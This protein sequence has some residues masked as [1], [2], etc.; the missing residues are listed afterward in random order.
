MHEIR[1]TIYTL[2][3]LL[4]LSVSIQ[5]RSYVFESLTA[6]NGLSD[7]VVNAIYKDKAGYVWIGTGNS[8]AKYD[9]THLK[10]YL[11]P[12]SNEKLKRVNAITELPTGEIWI[13]NGLGLWRIPKGG[14]ELEKIIP[15]E[16][17]TAVYSLLTDSHGTL[18][19]GEES[20]LTIYKKGQFH[21]FSMETNQFSGWNTITDM[22]IQ[23][24]TTLWMS[25]LRG[26]VSFNLLTKEKLFYA[27][28][29]AKE[30]QIAF[31][32]IEQIGT[33][34]YLG[35]M[36]QGILSFNT[37]SKEFKSYVN[38]GCNVISDLSSDKKG[39]L[40]VATDGN[41]VHFIDTRTEEIT[42]SFRHEVGSIESIRSNSVYSLLVDREGEIWMGYYQMGLDYTLYQS[43]QFN[44][45]KYK[46]IFDSKDISIRTLTI[47]EEEKLIG[48]R[49]GLHF[50]DEKRERYI[51]YTSP[52]LRSSMIIC[53]YYYK[54]EYYIG[55]YGGGMYIFNPK[56]LTIRNFET[57]EED[58]FIKGQ[59]FS[60]T[61]DTL[62]Q[63]WIGT[64]A[65]LYCYKEGQRVHKFT[66]ANSK[67][68]EGN[69]YKI[70]FDSTSKGWICT[71]N[72][73]CI[74]EPSSSSLKTDI[75]PD[76]F[77]HKE[78]IRVIFED[79]NHD[80]YFMPDKGTMF[81]SNMAMSSFRRVQPETPL[82][83]KDGLFIIEDIK[84]WLWIGT[85][86]GIFKYDKKDT[87]IPYN[88]VDG[89]PNPTFTYCEP[90]IDKEGKIW[91]G[92]S[93]GLLYVDPEEEFNNRNPYPITFWSFHANGNQEVFPSPTENKGMELILNNNQQN[94]TIRF[95]DLTYTKAS[96]VNYEY[97]L[98]GEEN[99]WTTLRGKS[100]VT[101]YGLSQGSYRFCVRIAGNPDSEVGMNI[102]ITFPREKWITVTA[103]SI[104]LLVLGFL[105]KQK[106][107]NST[108]LKGKYIKS[109]VTISEKKKE[110]TIK[111]NDQEG[112]EI[113]EDIDA[114]QS[115]EKEQNTD[116]EKY[117]TNK[118]S[119]KECKALTEKLERLMRQKKPFTNPN[120]KIADLATL[121][122]TAPHT[123]SFLFNQ[124]LHCTYYDY[125]NDYRV[126]EF[127]QLATDEKYAKYT[128]N[129]LAE[130][131]GFSSRASFF[132]HFKKATNITPNEYI[133]SLEKE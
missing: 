55:T 41:G 62:D 54:E 91:M 97:R 27:K 64:S 9:G 49:D 42:K 94:I 118:V 68:P 122:D 57:S 77:I 51:K 24:D 82:D 128:L 123:L 48:S 131:C 45:Y 46:K 61:S 101:Y 28:E 88:F 86:N 6:N 65:G 38:V 99:E 81:I 7:Q 111:E 59:I 12:G 124:H 92:N 33:T 25:T 37:E 108:T 16:I 53:S 67:L 115:V 90:I 102:K 18:Y 71:E 120:L 69:V 79:T 36:R 2:T 121:L 1:K 60:I 13:G 103:V 76:G 85:N 15:E 132:R 78:K 66:S 39:V 126:A 21:H 129:T 35:T 43:G 130:I 127:K 95:S 89:I 113:V 110:N 52:T 105:W 8:L 112:C 4:I 44:I 10:N 119:T 56:T 19:I 30:N 74:W 20:G 5:A 109:T 125:I 23:Q 17:S 50:I 22:V 133:R 3:T 104:L 114:Y 73:M 58:P 84:N 14:D 107:K 106:R 47:H 80:L 72:G 100:E 70:F 32:S 26:L 63:L 116:S 11:I 96:F 87:F 93:K 31:H 98:I 29:Y 117:K 83:G 34:L 40:Y 75:F